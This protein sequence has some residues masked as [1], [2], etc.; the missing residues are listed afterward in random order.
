MNMASDGEGMFIIWCERRRLK[1]E[2]TKRK[3][4]MHPS[5]KRSGDWAVLLKS[6]N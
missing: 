2:A 3:Y 1:K 5:F 6:G 4:S